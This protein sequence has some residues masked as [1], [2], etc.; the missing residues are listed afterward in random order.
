LAQ[1]ATD[2]VLGPI[3]NIANP[4]TAF[5][6][7]SAE[8]YFTVPGGNFGWGAGGTGKNASISL[9]GVYRDRCGHYHFIDTG[10]I[11]SFNDTNTGAG[12]DVSAFGIQSEISN[13]PSL[14]GIQS[15]AQFT[16][17]DFGPAT[18]NIGSGG[19]NGIWSAGLGT[20]LSAGLGVFSGTSDTFIH[21]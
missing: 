8:T 14:A 7:G 3:S 11:V 1:T 17:A 13:S 16:A 10:D 21:H 4:I 5:G 12:A 20:G 6:P 19:K 18:L 9:F 2:A 15:I